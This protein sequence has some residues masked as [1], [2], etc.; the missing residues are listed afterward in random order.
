EHQR[1]RAE[2]VASLGGEASLSSHQLA[3]VELAVGVGAL[4]MDFQTRLAAGEQIDAERFIAA[5]KE[6]RRILNELKLP[7]ANSAA[8]AAQ[9]VHANAALA[10]RR[11]T[12]Q[13]H[14]AKRV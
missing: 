2:L 11:P 1:R 9:S 10:K 13:D 3:L 6:Q 4:V 7:R 14:I 12:L 5:S 8:A